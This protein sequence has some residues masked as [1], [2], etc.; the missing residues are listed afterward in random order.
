MLRFRRRGSDSIR[1]ALFGAG[2]MGSVAASHLVRLKEIDGL[3]LADQFPERAKALASRL[4]SRKT[5]A[6]PVT[7]IDP[8]SLAKT[9][10]GADLAINAAHASLDLS[11]MEACLDAGASYMDLSSLPSRQFPLDARFRK[12]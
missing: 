7:S 3:V 12:A 2:A 4:K 10:E 6:V 9:L 11:L 8:G 5:R 1:I